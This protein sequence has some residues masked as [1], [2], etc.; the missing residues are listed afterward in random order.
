V[1]ILVFFLLALVA[2]A[3]LA[4]PLLPGRATTQPET[5][6]TDTDIDREVRHLLRVRAKGG[7]SCPACGRAHQPGDQFCAGCGAALPKPQT[8]P[9]GPVCPSCG[10]AIRHGDQFCAKCGH[11][12]TTKE[13]A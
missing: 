8:A 10:A 12:M 7:H 4:Y 13:A 6:V 3:I 9:A 2:A 1:G 11:R 5:S